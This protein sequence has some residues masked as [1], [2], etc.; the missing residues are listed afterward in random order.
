VIPACHL[1]IDQLRTSQRRSGPLS[2]QSPSWFILTNLNM[3]RTQTCF[4]CHPDSL[5]ILLDSP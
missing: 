3:G 2:T 4:A 5:V 1:Q